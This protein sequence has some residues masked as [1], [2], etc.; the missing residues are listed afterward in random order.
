MEMLYKCLRTKLCI[1]NGRNFQN[2]HLRTYIIP[3]ILKKVITETQ[4]AMYSK[5]LEMGDK[6]V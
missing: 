2:F 1:A 4:E 6:S 5:Y 3:P